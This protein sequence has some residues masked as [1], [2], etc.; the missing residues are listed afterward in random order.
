[1]DKKETEEKKTATK[2]TKVAEF[3]V[4]LSYS[5]KLKDT[6]PIDTFGVTEEGISGQL[7]LALTRFYEKC[8]DKSPKALTVLEALGA[9]TLSAPLESEVQITVGGTRGYGPG[10]TIWFEFGGNYRIHAFF[11][12]E[13]KEAYW[14]DVCVNRLTTEGFFAGVRG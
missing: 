7:K 10:A 1:M 11:Q 2:K 4:A 3:A 6:R 14:M 13:G 8:G 12:S 9:F 5:P